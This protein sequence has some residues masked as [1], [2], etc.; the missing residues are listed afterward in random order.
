MR[1][2]YIPAEE[3]SRLRHLGIGAIERTGIFADACRLNAL[4]MI[5]EAGSGHIGSSFSAMDI[6][7][8]LHLCEMDERGNAPRDLY[9]SSK[10]HDAP[11]LYSV[12]VGI[13]ALDYGMLRK[14]RRLGGL[15]GHP[16]VATPHAVCNT[17]SLGMGVSK[18]K[19]FVQAA[20]LAGH[21][22]RVFV[23]TGDGELQEGQ[24]WESLQGAAI[25]GMHEITV[26]VDHNKMQSDTW[27][28][29]VS[30]LGDL[31]AK[32]AAY[33][34]HV[35]RCNGH[36]LEQLSVVLAGFRN[37]KDRP[38]VLIADTV[39]GRG[40]TAMQNTA[41]GED[42]LY[43]FHSGAPATD[44]YK[45]SVDELASRV[46]AALRAAQQAPLTVE[47]VDAPDRAMPRGERLIGAYAQALV[48]QARKRPDLVVLDADLMLDCG[49]IPFRD[50]FPARFIECGIA[51]QD[52][53]S[54]AGALALQG[55][56]PVVH[57]FACFLSTRPNE[58]IYNNA[59]EHSKVIYVGSLA[60]LIPSGPGHSHQSVRDISALAAV[61]GLTLIEPSCEEETTLAL[62]YCVNVS[63]N[64][65]Y[66][67]LVS[68]P[69]EI[70][71]RLPPG[72]RLERGRGLVLR[73]G[74]TAVLFGYGPLLLAQACRAAEILESERDISLEI[75]N[76][77]WLN[78][79]D[80]DWLRAAVGDRT[81][82]FTLD[83]HYIDGGQG[84]MLL[85]RLAELGLAARC[86]VT[87]IGLNEIPAC[88]QNA[89]V[90]RA[91]ALD[92]EGLAD[93][94]ARALRAA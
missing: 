17:G 59:T 37:L 80:A 73:P 92:A 21:A 47:V 51:E 44:V 65:C 28:E 40:V 22:R 10:G 7:A 49:L 9:F 90:L 54:Q 1:L 77:P 16:D 78:E 2:T 64:S 3:L 86:R 4:S 93:T 56:L 75:V 25:H 88:G 81:H 62:D 20:R 74:S 39:K 24:F 13:G 71:Y 27:V 67:R 41:L 53:V 66:L 89:E 8:W 68:V 82:A 57:S 11:G 60:G 46:N 58:Q 30:G 61:P 48:E 6:V 87:R 45:A 36:D 19:G 18:A 72:Y 42:E 29:K 91:H 50:A 94:V 76:L 26:I 55:V 15:P 31:E 12:L 33:G 43:R 5:M 35:R 34:W 70:P 23:L 83:N 38:K 63:P 52:M 14:L 69:C 85:A 32:F 79:V 84:Q